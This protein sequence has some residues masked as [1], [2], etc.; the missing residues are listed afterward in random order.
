VSGQSQ[1][2]PGG[3]PVRKPSHYLAGPVETIDVIEAAVSNHTDPIAAVHH[4]AALKY[5]LRLLHKGKTIEDAK[6][7]RQYLNR[8][9][10]RLEGSPAGW[11]DNSNQP[12]QG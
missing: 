7:A 2:D 3:D 1:P 8:L 6:K 10:R 11:T 9:I 4:A 5:L 12:T